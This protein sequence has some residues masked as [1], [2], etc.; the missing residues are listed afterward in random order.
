VKK[1]VSKAQ[2]AEPVRKLFGPEKVSF[3]KDVSDV[4]EA[5]TSLTGVSE[6]VSKKL[7]PIVGSAIVLSDFIPGGKAAK[8]NLSRIAIDKQV[9]DYVAKSVTDVPVRM[10]SPTGSEL[11]LTSEVLESF[12][13]KNN[14]AQVRSEIVE[15][16]GANESE[17][18]VK[19][20][21][22]DLV[23]AKTK[24]DV[25]TAFAKSSYKI[26][27]P[28]EL[29]ESILRPSLNMPDSVK[30]LAVF[31]D[32]FDN[33]EDFTN[34]LSRVKGK[35]VL[36]ENLT[37]FENFIVNASDDD[38]VKNMSPEDF[39]KQATKELE[40]AKIPREKLEL[41]K[42]KL[43]RL[44]FQDISDNNIRLSRAVSD[45]SLPKLEPSVNTKNDLFNTT[46]KKLKN[47][48][49]VI[50]IQENYQNQWVRVK[51]LMEQKGVK[52]SDESNPF[53][54]RVLFDG[55][56]TAKNENL[57]KAVSSIQEE[58]EKTS[59]KLKVDANDIRKDINEYLIARHAP[60]RNKA[61]GDGAA[62]ITNEEAEEIL[63]KYRDESTISDSKLPVQTMEE[64]DNEYFS[65]LNEIGNIEDE[66]EY[67]LKEL[68]IKKERARKLKEIEGE[69]S[70]KEFIDLRESVNKGGRL[71]NGDFRDYETLQNEKTI[72]PL[73]LEE[74]PKYKDGQSYANSFPDVFHGSDTEID[75]FKFDMGGLNTGALNAKEGVFFT[76]KYD[77]AAVYGELALIN[78]GKA[79][80]MKDVK[81]MARK[82]V[83][84]IKE[85]DMQSKNRVSNDFSDIFKK[86][87]EEGY[88]G[89]VIRNTKDTP[90][91]LNNQTE[92]IYVAF[93]NNAIKKES[94]VI[95][96]Y[97][98]NKTTDSPDIAVKPSRDSLYARKVEQFANEIQKINNE[99]LDILLEGEV[100]TKDLHDSLRKK[101]P[102]H[103]PLNR[104]MDEMSD[105]DFI[106]VLG[107]KGFDVRGAGI[108]K[109]VGS[110]REVSDI[111]GNVMA[112]YVQ[113]VERAYKNKVNLA[114]LKL[115][116]ENEAF[117]GLFQEVKPKAIGEKFDGSPIYE[118][119]SDNSILSVRE[120]G[121]QVNLKVN[122]PDLAIALKSI[123]KEDVPSLI[124]TI[125]MVT[126][127]KAMTSTLLNPEFWITN[128]VRDTQDLAVNA[129]TLTGRNGVTKQPKSVQ[130][131][132]GWM[133]GKDTDGARLYEQMRADGGTTGGMALS[134][135]QEIDLNIDSMIKDTKKSPRSAFKSAFKAIENTN[136]IFEDAT[137]LSAYKSAL[138][139]GMSRDK[140]AFVAKNATVNFNMKGKQ[141]GLLNALYMFSNASI[142]GSVRTMKSL[143]DPKTLA[144]V[145][146][147]LGGAVYLSHKQNDAIDPDWRSKITEYDKNHNL[148]FV[149]PQ[150]GTIIKD[151][152]KG[153]VQSSEGIKYITFP[154]SWGLKPIKVLMDRSYEN[155]TG[156]LLDESNLLKD[157]ANS[158]MDAYNPVGGTDFISTATP[159]ILDLP[160]EI[161]RN[162]AWHGGLVFPEWK[163]GLPGSEQV[164]SENATGLKE[165][166]A[167][168]V[169]KILEDTSIDISPESLE[170]IFDYL[171]GGTGKAITRLGSTIG[172]VQGKDTD[173]RDLFALN[174]FY[175][176]K[177]PE[178]VQWA[179]EAKNKET[180]LKTLKDTP[181]QDRTMV[182][183]EFIQDMEQDEAKKFLFQI[184]ELGYDTKGVSTSYKLRDEERYYEVQNFVKKGD[185]QSAI[186]I[187]ESM[188]DEEYESYKKV[189]T[190]VRRNN[191]SELRSLLEESPEKAVAF[192]RDQTDEEQARLLKVMTDEEYQVYEKGKEKV[193][194]T[195]DEIIVDS[196]PES[197]FKEDEAVSKISLFAKALGV[198]PITAFKT[199]SS[200]NNIQYVKDGV[201]KIERLPFGE[202]QEVRKNLGA[203]DTVQLDHIVPLQLGGTNNENNLELV[204]IEIHKEFTR[205]GNLLRDKVEEDK[206]SLSK[207]QKVIKDF[208]KGEVTMEDIE[209]L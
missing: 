146:G 202:S 205:A 177:T 168:K 172:A 151:D 187:I 200:K 127:F 70:F 121:E 107:T 161:A 33:V 160:V 2:E 13:K 183:K 150:K 165:K 90:M 23:S 163:K 86:A 21:S 45:V 11:D 179:T 186:E 49:A 102:N 130:D 153:F 58:I 203:D 18:L 28:D 175:K 72:R 154:V 155:A 15:T 76:T 134:T 198:S 113:A 122:D 82:F 8:T 3:K 87:K 16:F 52:F 51:R 141:T 19:Q 117:G 158:L 26:D 66:Q 201:I 103:I 57:K 61:L 194:Q 77:T 167:R 189:K 120:K 157:V 27:M 126:K 60:E 181:T 42:T 88:D 156:Q 208:R 147:V 10:V 62:G 196:F 123:G 180:I 192:L 173:A 104:V 4:G 193:K 80:D 162:K 166:G 188:T 136:Q 118:E 12:T 100:I 176:E 83:G 92:D 139:A 71:N 144:K 106:S 46:I 38:F 98:K 17:K 111:V 43:S 74:L 195:Q 67:L 99:V 31:A 7:G 73:S 79:I 85:V 20:L 178:Q 138:E 137:R 30:P 39:Y 81:V 5:L 84:K 6:E 199:L 207:A 95:E 124:R 185:D 59:K 50:K 64:L 35:T 115:S 191:T 182:I 94:D 96:F 108:K 132:I 44:S 169:S 14:I 97:N 22:K 135:R 109:A 65:K 209:K 197:T 24:E 140:A 171:I 78:K 48:E 143:S 204:P 75:D 125:G 131:I 133:N 112:N 47:T 142:Q 40:L 206:I 34:E 56:V 145:A 53:Q 68:E 1:A 129:S 110:E 164:F 25:A 149:L 152:S 9:G 101:Y 114:T 119:L 69:L 159:T 190:S 55:A 128:V 184:R 116:R 89:V 170:Y 91:T 63:K 54:K 148:I 29:I 93:N 105:N 36:G 32:K 41:G 174:R 37:P